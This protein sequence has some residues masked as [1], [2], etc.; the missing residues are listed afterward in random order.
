MKSRRARS[1]REETRKRGVRKR[2]ESSFP[3][4]LAAPTI[5][6]AFSRGSS[7]LAQ[8]GK[9]TRRLKNTRLKGSK[10]KASTLYQRVCKDFWIQSSDFSQTFSKAITSFYRL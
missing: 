5:A 9:L 7:S 4:P 10:I 8:I 2:K 6:R 3:R 1:T